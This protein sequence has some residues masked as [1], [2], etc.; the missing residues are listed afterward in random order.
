MAQP[1][2]SFNLADLFESVSDALPDREAVV[3]GG[4][5][6]SYRQL[7]ERANRL[8]HYLAG[9][10]VKA[11]DHVGLYLYNCSAY[12]EGM[13]ACFKL[14][15]VPININYRYLEEELRYIFDN[16]DLVGVIHGREFLP[17]I[18]S[19]APSLPKL[20]WLLYLEDG[21]Q[22]PLE[23]APPTA[24]YEQALES[25]D[26]RRDFEAR[27]DDDWFILYTGGTTGAP[28]GVIWPHKALVFGAFYGF[29]HHHPEGAVKT[30][31]EVSARARE[32]YPLISVPLAPMMHGACWW[33]ACISLLSGHKLVLY[34]E[35]SLQGDKVWQLVEQEKINSISLVGDAMAIPLLDALKS[36]PGRWDLSSL[37]TIGSGGAVFSPV[38]QEEYRRLFPNILLFNSFGSSE[39]G[40]QGG[41]TGQPSAG[42]GRLERGEHADVVSEDHR[43]V[44]PGSGQQGYLA[45]S[46]HI[47]LGYYKDPQK[48][49]AVFV[50]VEGKNWALTGDRATVEKDGTIVVYGR[51]SYCINSGGEKIFPEEVEQAVK[52]HPRIFDVLVVG[53]P[54]P[55]YTEQVTAVVQ[56]RD[57]DPL[58]LREIQDNCRKHI[59]GYKLPRELHRIERIE[60][61]PSGKP[62]YRWAREIALSGE[63]LVE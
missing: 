1:N 24:E 57:A 34:P 54:H 18:R 48:S 25:S 63:Y 29:G 31:A 5:R 43:L 38:V 58:S 51:S 27:S 12:L 20:A 47:P 30:P 26:P 8:A 33:F 19:I 50:T 16:A 22:E 11:R 44:P 42:L 32:G 59:A 6:L 7:D 61:S 52:N 36:N 41:D 40:F 56:T 21:S 2:I 35:K 9:Q 45:R 53:T 4:Q 55:R 10:G 60:R 49:A 15:A 37:L 28:K 46:G 39:T 17:R 13:L 23:G 62:D 3:A 14:R